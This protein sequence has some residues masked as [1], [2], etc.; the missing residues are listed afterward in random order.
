MLL[1]IDDNINDDN[2]DDM[3]SEK[4]QFLLSLE[5]IWDNFSCSGQTDYRCV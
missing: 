2:A 4:V 1:N 5:E 3:W